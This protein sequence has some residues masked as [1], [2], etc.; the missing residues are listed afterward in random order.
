MNVCSSCGYVT[1]EGIVV[2][3][4]IVAE[5]KGE[6][7]CGIERHK[8]KKEKRKEKID[9]IHDTILRL[10]ERWHF[11]QNIIWQVQSDFK[12]LTNNEKTKNFKPHDLYIY[13][14]YKMLLYNNCGRTPKEIMNVL[15]LSNKKILYQIS[16]VDPSQYYHNNDKA[17]LSSNSFSERFCSVLDLNHEEKRLI[18]DICTHLEDAELNLRPQS[19]CALVIFTFQKLMKDHC[20]PL[21][22]KKKLTIKSISSACL[23]STANLLRNIKLHGDIAYKATFNVYKSR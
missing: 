21:S 1:E 5:E 10:K 4:E 3:K 12:Y 6:D 17:F 23:T 16:V 18:K 9:N 8:S 20:K 11:P 22:V 15:P 19:L 13:S 14:F 7:Y 2:T